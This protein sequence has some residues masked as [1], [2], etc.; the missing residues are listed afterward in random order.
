LAS[1]GVGESSFVFQAVAPN[2]FEGGG[3]IL[4]VTPPVTLAI[5]P[6]SLVNIYPVIVLQNAFSRRQQLIVV[7]P[8][9]DAGL[10]PLLPHDQ[11]VVFPN[12]VDIFSICFFANSFAAFQILYEIAA[13]LLTRFVIHNSI[14][15]PLE[16][17]CQRSRVL[18]PICV[19]KNSFLRLPQFKITFEKLARFKDQDA[20]TTELVV[21]KVACVLLYFVIIV[22]SLQLASIATLDAVHKS[23]SE[24]SHEDLVDVDALPVLDLGAW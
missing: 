21:S 7:R 6:G 17:S 14:A 20:H 23:A 16:T 15:F 18:L 11:F 3:C 1:S 19:L 5:L 8:K 12:P 4:K 22:K 2:A 10:N 13:I 24:L 9:V